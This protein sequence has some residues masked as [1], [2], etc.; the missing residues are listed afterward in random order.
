[1]CFGIEDVDIENSWTSGFS[2][3]IYLLG[4]GNN[5]S[6]ILLTDLF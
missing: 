2:H 5:A 1:M 6:K 3:L 4:F